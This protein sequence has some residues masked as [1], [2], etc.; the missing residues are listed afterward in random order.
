MKYWMII[1]AAALALTACKKK[2]VEAEPEDDPL[3]TYN[4]VETLIAYCDP[5]EGG[6]VTI[7]AAEFQMGGTVYPEEGPVRTVEVGTFNIDVHEVT[8]KQFAEFVDATGYV[9]DAEKEQLGFNMT[10]GAVF[11]PPTPAHQSWWRFIEGANW[12]QP[13]G[14]DSTI[15]GK[16][17]YPVVQ[18]S[19]NDAKAYAE[20]KGRRL[21]TE[22]EWEYAAGAG[23]LSAYVWGEERNPDGEEMANTWQGA[24]PVRDLGKD[25]HTGTAPVGCF[26]PNTFGLYDM[27]GNVWE[28]TDTLYAEGQGEPAF[29]IKGGS[30]LCADNYCARYRSAARQPQE[31]GLPTNHV[32]FRTVGDVED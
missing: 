31:I 24:F 2:T 7:E 17:N 5:P 18:V 25:G 13:E 14:P 32:G 16:D 3:N 15:A 11:M 12:Y 20:W 4:Q 1:G 8:N 29:V 27:I 26:K 22:A 30:F 6:P 9:T 28:W 21:P 23:A 10:G 19:W